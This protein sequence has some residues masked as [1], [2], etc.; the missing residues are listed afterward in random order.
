MADFIETL[1]REAAERYE[2]TYP[3]ATF[4]EVKAYL[5]KVYETK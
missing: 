5:N 4:A 1:T 3:Q 2:Y